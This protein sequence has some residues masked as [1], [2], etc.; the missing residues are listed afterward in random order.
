MRVFLSLSMLSVLAIG[1]G[2]APLDAGPNSRAQGVGSDDPQD[3]LDREKASQAAGEIPFVDEDPEVQTPAPPAP[4]PPTPPSATATGKDACLQFGS[5][6][7]PAVGFNTATWQYQVKNCQ[8]S[9]CWDFFSLDLQCNLSFQHDNQKQTTT[10]DTELCGFA[11][12]VLTSRRFTEAT[13]ACPAIVEPINESFEISATTV[14]HRKF[15]FCDT[16]VMEEA[17]SC[18]RWVV[19]TAFGK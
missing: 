13:Q 14:V 16:P 6:L 18:L 4:P 11:V 7:H 15:S 2:S 8:S 5:A 10:I 9:A 17:R 3:E 1:C 12:R 19:A